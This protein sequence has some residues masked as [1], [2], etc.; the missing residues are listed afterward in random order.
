MALYG[1]KSVSQAA[2]IALR[3][4]QDQLSAA[5]ADN[6]KLQQERSGLRAD[7]Q[8]LADT[9]NSEQQHN[10]AHTAKLTQQIS[11]MH[12]MLDEMKDALETTAEE[13]AK[14]TEQLE[15]SKQ[16]C[17]S[18][19]QELSTSRLLLQLTQRAHQQYSYFE[20]LLPAVLCLSC[21]CSSAANR[22]SCSECSVVLAMSNGWQPSPLHALGHEEKDHHNNT[23]VSHQRMYI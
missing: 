17:S 14:L 23:F 20:N 22:L 3:Q 19:G 10:D 4:L 11:E 6:A 16:R 13:N 12:A 1:T 7:M 9:H 8:E 5:Y 2:A 21:C 18:L 15:Q